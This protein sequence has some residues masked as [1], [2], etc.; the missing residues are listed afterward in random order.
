MNLDEFTQ[1]TLTV[2]SEGGIASY[3]PTI[4]AREQVRVIQGIPEGYDHR[5]AIQEVILQSRFE[6]E[7]FY[8]GVRSGHQEITTGHHLEGSTRFVRILGLTQGFTLVPVETCEW[9]RLDG[10]GHQPGSEH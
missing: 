10:P 5:E 2:A 3:A 1:I 6:N 7:E 9:W 4:I 8:F